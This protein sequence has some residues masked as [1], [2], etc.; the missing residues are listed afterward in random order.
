MKD[1]NSAAAGSPGHAEL[2]GAKADPEADGAGSKS[3]LNSA[4]GAEPLVVAPDVADFLMGM[5]VRSSTAA[6]SLQSAF[7]TASRRSPQ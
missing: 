7:C 2:S 1:G 4:A 5:R 3:E 6:A